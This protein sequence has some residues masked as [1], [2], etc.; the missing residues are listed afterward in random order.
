MLGFALDF[1]LVMSWVLYT[2]V[3]FRGAHRHNM[4]VRAAHPELL[5]TWEPFLLSAVPLLV[6]AAVLYT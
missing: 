6:V 4:R 5:V 1:V 2:V 3:M